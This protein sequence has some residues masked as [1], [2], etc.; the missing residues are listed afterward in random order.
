MIVITVL[1]GYVMHQ[2][3]KVKHTIQYYPDPVTHQQ[4]HVFQEHLFIVKI[5]LY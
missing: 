2:F 3:G 5:K 4:Q 1:V